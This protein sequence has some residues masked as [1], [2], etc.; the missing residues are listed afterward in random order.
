MV[1]IKSNIPLL[2]QIKRFITLVHVSFGRLC[3]IPHWLRL[4]AWLSSDLLLNYRLEDRRCLNKMVTRRR[5]MC[6]C[7]ISCKKT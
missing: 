7:D 6:Q 3:L 4:V 2:T 5:K 1:L